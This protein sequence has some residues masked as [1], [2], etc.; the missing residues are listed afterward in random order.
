MKT[1]FDETICF[2]LH[3]KVLQCLQAFNRSPSFRFWYAVVSKSFPAAEKTVFYVINNN[4]SFK[5]GKVPSPG[6]F[7]LYPHCVSCSLSTKQLHCK[8][9]SKSINSVT[10]EF[11]VGSNDL[12]RRASIPFCSNLF[13]SFL[14][15]VSL[16]LVVVTTSG[17]N[18]SVDWRSRD[19]GFINFRMSNLAA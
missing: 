5:A 10:S 16:M 7:F 8:E 6:F 9:K 11:N 1:D 2:K 17:N 15:F 4:L 13:S 3:F 12:S 19:V 14:I 18:R